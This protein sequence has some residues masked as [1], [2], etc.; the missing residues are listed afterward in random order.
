VINVNLS[1]LLFMNEE[2]FDFL[3]IL[4][5]HHIVC[6]L[7][8]KWHQS[9]KEHLHVNLC[10]DWL[11][12]CNKRVKHFCEKL[13]FY[14]KNFVHVVQQRIKS[15]YLTGFFLRDRK[16]ARGFLIDCT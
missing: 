9:V 6:I 1:L 12:F 16:I 13:I 10:C 3:V 15:Y 8:P 4:V 14:S 5:A 11:P 2:L 7:K